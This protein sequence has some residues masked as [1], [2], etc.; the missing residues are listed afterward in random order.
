M[1]ISISKVC[2]EALPKVAWWVM[3]VPWP[4]WLDLARNLLVARACLPPRMLPGAG[5]WSF[6]R[7]YKVRCAA[8]LGTMASFT[9]VLPH[10][11]TDKFV[12][13]DANSRRVVT[14]LARAIR[15][16]HQPSWLLLPCNLPAYGWPRGV[17]GGG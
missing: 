9:I 11:L 4:S 7:L 13:K 12:V 17:R 2:G 16:E 10:F 5:P 14:L 6:A 8:S 15:Q 3:E 1:V